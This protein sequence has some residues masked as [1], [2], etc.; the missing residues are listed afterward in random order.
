[1]TSQIEAG[2]CQCQGGQGS[3]G[4]QSGQGVHDRQGGRGGQGHGQ[5]LEL[6]FVSK[7]AITTDSPPG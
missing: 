5:G 4:D 7:V 6:L 3:Q 1:M 2:H